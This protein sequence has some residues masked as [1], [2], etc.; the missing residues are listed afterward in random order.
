MYL[1][2]VLYYSVKSFI[3]SFDGTYCYLLLCIVVPQFPRII[4]GLGFFLLNVSSKA[5][6]KSSGAQI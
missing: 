1:A 4:F 2:V 6:W 3:R 5:C